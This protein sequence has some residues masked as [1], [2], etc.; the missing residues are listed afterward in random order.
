MTSDRHRSAA[1]RRQRRR[2]SFL[3][4]TFDREAPQRIQPIIERKPLRLAP[5][6]GA[7]QDNFGAS[8][9]DP[10]ELVYRSSTIG[11]VIIGTAKSLSL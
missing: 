7:Y 10:I 3:D 11:N 6:P 9:H 4:G 1:A 2:P 5:A 8:L